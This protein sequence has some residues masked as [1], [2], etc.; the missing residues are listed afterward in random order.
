MASR[1]V[2]YAISSLCGSGA[3][4][5]LKPIGETPS[6][7]NAVAIVLAVNCPPQAPSP[8]HDAHSTACSSLSSILPALRAPIASKMS[9]T[10]IRLPLYSPYMIEPP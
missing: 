10:V 5:S 1:P 9:C 6:I 3:G 7:A 4:T 8:G 2:W